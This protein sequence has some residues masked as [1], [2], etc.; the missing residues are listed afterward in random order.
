MRTP[1]IRKKND[2]YCI[3]E[4][5]TCPIRNFWVIVRR[6]QQLQQIKL[7]PP[8][9]SVIRTCKIAV[10]CNAF[11]SVGTSHFRLIHEKLGVHQIAYVV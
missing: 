3:P 4:S 9:L 8:T 5:N 2:D 6:S 1:L 7:F 11:T 10:R